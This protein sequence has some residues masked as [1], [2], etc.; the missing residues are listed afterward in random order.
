MK[1]S[2]S[3]LAKDLI[4]NNYLDYTIAVG[5]ERALPDFADGLK[6]IQRKIVWAAN[7]MNLHHDK[8]H[9]KS[10]KL[11]GVVMGNFSPHADSYSSVV[12]LAQDACPVPLLDGQGNWGFLANGEAAASR[13][14]E[15]RLSEFSEKYLLDKDYLAVTKMLPNYDDTTLEPLRLPAL[16]PLLLLIGSRGIAVGTRSN[17]PNFTWKSLKPLILKS[18]KGEKITAKDCLSL[19]FDDILNAKYVGEKSDLVNYYKTG[20]GTLKFGVDCEIK[21]K[22]IHLYSLTSSIDSTLEK[23][24]KQDWVYGVDDMSNAHGIDIVIRPKP[25]YKNQLED[26]KVKVEKLLTSSINYSLATNMIEQKVDIDVASKQKTLYKLGAKY[27]EINIPTYIEK[28]VNYRLHLEKDM[29]ENRIKITQKEIDRL[30][31]IVWSI[32]KLAIIFKVLKSKTKDLDSA[33]A[34]ALHIDL[35]KAKIIAGFTVRQLS[36]LNKE[37][38]ENKIRELQ[39]AVRQDEDCKKHLRKTVYCKIKEIEIPSNSYNNRGGKK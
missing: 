36:N 12:L 8:A 22:A 13:Y 38:L 27:L 30:Q 25:A 10:A 4:A 11:T 2:N 7:F 28:W 15:V 1:V 31:F 24:D 21:D 32:S 29:L 20:S 18:I 17:I 16:V 6:P 9:I 14:T 23:L 33:L 37:T 3:I 5:S 35:E 34:K 39:K 26:I 19:Q